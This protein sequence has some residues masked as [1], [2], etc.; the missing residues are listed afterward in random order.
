MS[1]PALTHRIGNAPYA[2][3]KLCFTGVEPGEPP[4][5]AMSASF[6]T[7]S[8]VLDFFFTSLSLTQRVQFSTL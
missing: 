5:M 4:A 2:F 3:A 7:F 1:S 8:L 6:G